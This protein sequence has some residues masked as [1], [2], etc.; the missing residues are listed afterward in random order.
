VKLLHYFTLGSLNTLVSE[1]IVGDLLINTSEQRHMSNMSFRLM[2]VYLRFRER[3][4]KPEEFLKR[5]GI[6]EGQLVLDYG[7]GAGS[8]S[9]PAAKI[10]GSFG[11][12]YAL[13]IHPLAIKQVQKRA[14]KEGIT[15]LAVIHSGLK[16]GLE[17]SH[18]DVILLLDVFSWVKEKEELLREFHR[19]LKPNGK[20][21]IMVDHISPEKCEEIVAGV[22]LFDLENKEE[23]L[24]MYQKI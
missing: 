21:I 22:E 10:V 4:R 9:I 6:L 15:N 14:Q 13:D 1:V 5:I 8:Y 3:F 19:V 7:C 20:L 2:S 12:I 24:F 17:D 11:K 16:T 18:L 23:N